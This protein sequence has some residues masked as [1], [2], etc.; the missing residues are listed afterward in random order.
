MKD[1]FTRIAVILDRSGSMSTIEGATVE[2]FNAFIDEQKKTPGDVTVKLVKFNAQLEVTFD[3]KLSEVPRLERLE[4]WG[5]TALYDAMGTTISHLGTELSNLPESER[6]SKV[7]IVTMT[8]GDENSSVK[9]RH[10]QLA[11]LIKQQTEKYNWEFVFLGANI[12]A[13][14]VANYLNIPMSNAIHYYAN[15]GATRSIMNA[16]AKYVTGIRT[17]VRGQTISGT[18][19]TEEERKEAL[20]SK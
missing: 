18:G 11:S 16:T 7:I 12:D 2:G 13:I 5:G 8:D 4:P 19:F 20:Q 3:S 9:W 1:N 14:R 10:E 17:G 15:A 6:P